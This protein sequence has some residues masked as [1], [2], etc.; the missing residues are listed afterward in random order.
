LTGGLLMDGMDMKTGQGMRP[1]GPALDETTFEALRQRIT[2][3]SGIYIPADE[4]SRFVLERRLS[5]RLR[6]RG[7]TSFTDN[8][9]GLDERELEAVLDVIAIHETYFFREKRQLNVF[10]DQ[11]LGEV[12]RSRREVRIWSAGCSTGEEAYTIS[13]LLA[14]RGMAEEGRVRVVASDLSRRVLESALRGS[15]GTS[16]F[17]TTEAQYKE[18]YFKQVGDGLW[19]IDEGLRE[20]VQFEQFNLMT[21]QG[22]GDSAAPGGQKFDVIFCRNVLMY[23]D[24]KAVRETLSAFHSLLEEGGYLLLGHAESLLPLSTGFQSVQFGRE[25]VH[26]K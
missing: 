17:R 23:F 11:I 25:L 18:K 2:T 5:P 13:M 21:L 12:G 24:E 16:S 4:N 1:R 15:Y 6:T 26:K 22:R 3:A 7:L 19:Q 8:E 14:E 9:S 10:A 20:A